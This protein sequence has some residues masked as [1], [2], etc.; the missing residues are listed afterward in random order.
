MKTLQSILILCTSILLFNCSNSTT[1]SADE[2]RAEVNNP[3]KNMYVIERDIPGAGQLTADE[4]QGISQTSCSVLDNLGE[5]NIEWLHSYVT[6][7]KVYCVY[8][9]T[10]IDMVKEHA[11]QGGFPA[12]SI[13]KVGTVIDPSTAN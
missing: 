2:L 3:D 6:N 7:D 8:M 13:A 11:K 4:L 10:N 1:S 5:D 12:N 9:A